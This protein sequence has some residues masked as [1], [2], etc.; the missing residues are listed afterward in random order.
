MLAISAVDKSNALAETL[1]QKIDNKT[2]PLGALGLLETVALQIGC[3]QQSLTPILSNPQVL[4]FASDHGLAEAGVSAFPSEVTQQMVYNFLNGGAGINVFCYQHGLTLQ[5]VDAGVN[6]DF[7]AH[8]QLIQAKIQAG[9]HNCLNQ[10]A[11][12]DSDCRQAL[13]QGASIIDTLIAQD[14]NTVILGEMGIGNTASASLLM[15]KLTGIALDDCIGNG[16][17][18]DVQGLAKKQQILQ[19]VINKYPDIEQPLAVLA[20]FGGFEIAMMVGAYL[21]AGQ[22]KMTIIVDGFIASVALLVAVKLAPAVI[23]Y[24]IFSHQSDEK[25]HGA[26]LNYLQVQPL[27]KLNLR[28]GEGTGAVLAYPLVQSAI[29]FLN[30]MQ[31]FQQANVSQQ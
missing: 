8:P 9:T 14:C 6:H 7:P 5:V 20:T 11:M 15:H 26:L 25:G 30:E 12:S 3:I 31:S 28:L 21:Q 4:V 10:P 17:G 19:Q 13:Q 29:A 27:L 23:D 24:C 22:Q 2:K 1:Q 16:T 18:L